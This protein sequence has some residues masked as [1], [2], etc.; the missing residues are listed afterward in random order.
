MNVFNLKKINLTMKNETEKKK[1]CEHKN[2]R[3]E[4]NEYTL[5]ALGYST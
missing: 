5:I 2:R 1:N 3:R 4:K